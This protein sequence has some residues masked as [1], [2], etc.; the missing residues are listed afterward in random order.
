MSD[1]GRLSIV[2]GS[3]VY[4][5][6]Q[7]SDS[8]SLPSIDN[9]KSWHNTAERAWRA[10]LGNNACLP[11]SVSAAVTDENTGVQFLILILLIP[12]KW[13]I[14]KCVHRHFLHINQFNLAQK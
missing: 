1:G 10:P 2:E 5:V 13:T 9:S 4:R 11:G 12:E 14:E 8:N 6:A 3:E 7:L